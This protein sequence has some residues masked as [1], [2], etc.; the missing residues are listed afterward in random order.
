MQPKTVMDE[1]RENEARA[2]DCRTCQSG[3]RQ[4][5]VPA[6]RCMTVA[7]PLLSM[8]GPFLVLERRFPA[9]CAGWRKR[10]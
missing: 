5:N 10:T 8:D 2:K 9:H 4:L 1:I 3:E 6:Y 7:A